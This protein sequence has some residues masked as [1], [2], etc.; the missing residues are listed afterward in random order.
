MTANDGGVTFFKNAIGRIV[1]GRSLSL[2]ITSDVVTYRADVSAGGV[3]LDGSGK[4]AMSIDN[5]QKF[6]DV[7]VPADTEGTLPSESTL[8][9][10]G[11]L[12]VFNVGTKNTVFD[13]NCFIDENECSSE[14]TMVDTAFGLELA[15]HRKLPIDVALSVPTIRVNAFEMANAIDDVEVGSPIAYVDVVGAD[16]SMESNSGRS[17]HFADSIEYPQPKT[18]H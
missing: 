2:S 9:E 4:I 13:L 12:H 7:L 10:V 16:Y 14:N 15:V 18:W 3:G 6:I 5:V 1:D 8:I 11:E 17:V